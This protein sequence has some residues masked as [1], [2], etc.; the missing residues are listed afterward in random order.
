MVKN[1]R[2]NFLIVTSISLQN[3]EKVF[4]RMLL[5]GLIVYKLAL[6]PDDRRVEDLGMS[7]AGVL[8]VPPMERVPCEGPVQV[9]VCLTCDASATLPVSVHPRTSPSSPPPP[10]PLPFSPL[11]RH[12]T[13]PRIAA[14]QCC[15]VA[16]TVIVSVLD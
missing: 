7:A 10:S 12:A 6:R 13:A 16:S 4:D 3:T 8:V 15:H 11:L 2:Y 9:L 14:A 5:A 1:S